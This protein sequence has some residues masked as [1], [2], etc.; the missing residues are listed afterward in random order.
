ML[1]T[2]SKK[3][4]EFRK[5]RVGIG[6]DS[7][8]RRNGSEL[9][10]RKTGDNEVDDNIGD[11]VGK[12]G[13]KTFKFKNLFKKLSKSKKT[14]GSDFFTSRSRLAFTKLRQLF[15]KAPILYHFDLECHIRVETDASGYAIVGI[16]SQLT[17]DDLG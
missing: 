11:E 13:Q 8:A 15:V 10:A 17:L 4:A 6:I 14:V 7:R 16:F 5:V 1:K 12:K 9:D 2:S 3:L